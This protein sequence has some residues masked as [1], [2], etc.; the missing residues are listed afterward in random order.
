L[1]NNQIWSCSNAG[2]VS[3]QP[4]LLWPEHISVAHQVLIGI[5]EERLI[6]ATKQGSVA[7]VAPVESL[8]IDAVYV[9]HD[10][11]EIASRCSHTQMIVIAHQTIDKDFD[12]PKPMRFG[13]RIEKRLIVRPSDKRRLSCPTRRLLFTLLLLNLACGVPEQPKIV[14]I[15][16]S[17]AFRPS[18]PDEV[19]GVEQA[20]AAIITVGRDDLGL[21]V[22]D[23]LY[24]YVYK[25]SASFAYYGH[26]WNTLPFDVAKKAAFAQ[27]NK[28][29]LDLE[30]T[31]KKPVNF[32][33]ILAHEYAHNVQYALGGME[34][35]ISRW[36]SEGFADWFAERVF[37]YLKWQEYKLTLDRVVQDLVKHKEELPQ[38]SSLHNDWTWDRLVPSRTVSL[39][40]TD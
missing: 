40:P 11:G 4:A 13:D 8:R 29:N 28:I 3:S 38:I 34:P 2:A 25:N 17:A 20:M 39:K 32:I 21:P 24:V 26:G 22:V 6:T 12:A 18:K 30:K 15:S 33:R 7:L 23:P 5:D 35:R 14:A 1:T 37:H 19:Q 36:I 10:P 9:A 16:K 31:P 27:D